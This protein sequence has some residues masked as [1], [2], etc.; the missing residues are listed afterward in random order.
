M[1][2]RWIPRPLISCTRSALEELKVRGRSSCT[3]DEI[4]AALLDTFNRQ[5]QIDAAARLVA[6]DLILDHPPE[7]L[8]T[9]LADALLREDAGFH[10]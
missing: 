2:R 10:A 7:A 4:R 9:T 8:I 6:R 5:Q 3:A 1:N